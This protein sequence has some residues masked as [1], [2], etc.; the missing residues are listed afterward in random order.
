MQTIT[1]QVE[2]ILPILLPLPNDDYLFN[3]IIEEVVEEIVFTPI[4]FPLHTEDLLNQEVLVNFQRL[5]KDDGRLKLCRTGL[6]NHIYLV[7]NADLEVIDRPIYEIKDW[8]IS[9]IEFLSSS[10]ESNQG[11]DLFFSMIGLEALYCSSK[12]KIKKQLIEKTQIF[13]GTPIK[14]KRLLKNMY[15]YGSKII[16]GGLNFPGKYHIFDAMEEFEQY[17]NDYYYTILMAQ[18]VLLATIQQLIKRN[19]NNLSF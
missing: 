9:S 18:S 12:H 5:I 14:Y 16:H 3:G 7:A 6:R 10:S 13:L 15:N 11:M 1:R 17:E 19:M 4:I 8:G 2:I